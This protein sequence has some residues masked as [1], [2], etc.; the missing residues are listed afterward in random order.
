M[1]CR[2]FRKHAVSRSDLNKAI[3]LTRKN[4]VFL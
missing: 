4:V 1:S 2:V 3:N